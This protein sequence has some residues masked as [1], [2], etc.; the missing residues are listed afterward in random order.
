MILQKPVRPT[1]GPAASQAA[2]NR[3]L[4]VRATRGPFRRAF[5]FSTVD[6]VLRAGYFL[7]TQVVM[8]R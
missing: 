1:S 2:P 8:H 5:C 4:T 6:Y 3:P 7:I